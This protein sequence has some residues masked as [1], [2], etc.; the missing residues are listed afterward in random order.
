MKKL[1]L[2]LVIGLFCGINP[3]V[4][5]QHIAQQKSSVQFNI[6]GGGIFKV[7][8]T[9]TGMQG[10]FNFNPNQLESSSFNI[11]IDAASINTKNKK[12]DAH[13][14]NPDFFEVDKYP[15]ICF[16]SEQVI[17]KENYY[18]AI[19]KL[20]LHGVTQMVKIPFTFTNNTF[21]GHLTINR[22]DYNLGADFSTLRVGKEAKVTITCDVE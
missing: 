8:G 14:R 5:Q 6:T 19:G 9:F 11:C 18:V 12:R 15:N 22:F 1:A 21:N 4:A 3:I 20:S 16:V 13:L 10:N 2:F 17:T 7:K